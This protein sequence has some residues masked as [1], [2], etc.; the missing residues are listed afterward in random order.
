[1]AIPNSNAENKTNT[2]KNLPNHLKISLLITATSFLA[3]SIYW[4]V[5]APFTLH[6]LIGFF[7]SPLFRNLTMNNPFAF[8]LIASQEYSATIGLFVNLIAAILTFQCTLLLI[9][10]D[11]KWLK[12]LGNAL[13]FEAFW[14]IL[15]IPTSIHHLVGT[16]LSMNT[17]NVYVGLSYLLQVLLIA[18]PLIMLSHNLKKP[19]NHDLIRKWISLVAPLFVFG[20]WFKYLFL[21]IDTLSPLGPQQATLMSTLG[22]VNSF[23][24]LLIAG[25]LAAVACSVF[26]Q[27]KE[28]NK[29]LVGTAIILFG[30]YFII[31]D[32]VSIWVPVYASFLYL[33]DFWM[34]TLPIM[35]IAVLKKN[36]NT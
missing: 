27:K 20:F 34:I 5:K 17:A 15:L 30:T 10:N 31:Y 13:L 6:D 11:K 35:G 25:I 21:W 18:P 3:F 32:L 2:E 22:M 24:T 33:T 26:Y 36:S 14:F 8:P 4:A 12:P 19:Q 7:S 29:W 23:F 28:M 1:M 16:T 9:K